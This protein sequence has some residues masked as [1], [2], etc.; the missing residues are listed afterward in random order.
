MQFGVL[1]TDHGKHSDEKMAIATAAEIIQIGATAAGQQALDARKL[2]NEI[3]DVLTAH[4]AKVSKAEVD[5]LSADGAN[6]LTSRLDPRPHVDDIVD[7]VLAVC[8]ASAFK[9]WFERDEVKHW[10]ADKIASW[11]ATNMFMHR[12]WFS[13]GYVGHHLDLKRVADHKDDAEHVKWWKAAS[14]QGGHGSGLPDAIV[15]QAKDE[16]IGR[17]K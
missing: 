17:K 3:I 11:T 14:L 1:I 2:E 5:A 4:H 6:H 16:M 9:E 13:Q 15:Q 10:I 7:R 8:K 12:D